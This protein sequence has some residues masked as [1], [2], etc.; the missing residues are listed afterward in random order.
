MLLHNLPP[1]LLASVLI[2]F[3]LPELKL[4]K[5]VSHAT[6]N[7]C[8]RMLRSAEWS[9]GLN[10]F[11]M[12][13]E[14]STQHNYKLPM[15]VSIYDEC[16]ARGCQLIATV[17]K[18]KIRTVKENQDYIDSADRTQWNCD[19]I[20]VNS[21]DIVVVEMCIEVHGKG[22]V[23]S[24]WTLRR[25]IQEHMRKHA[26][27]DSVRGEK[28]DKMLPYTLKDNMNNVFVYDCTIHI[29]NQTPLSDLLYN[30]NP[31][32]EIRKGVWEAHRTPCPDNYG[33]KHRNM[34]VIEMCQMGLDLFV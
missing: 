12:A 28:A 17:Y 33:Y 23:G 6:A 16:F 13:E 34:N 10:E 27:E 3:S 19:Q 31:A 9:G 26:W 25:M 32:T 7:A 5:A 30:I 20:D 4:L 8:R 15:V 2:L 29:D 1:E 14:I 11:D 21:N 24:V 22:I 18:L